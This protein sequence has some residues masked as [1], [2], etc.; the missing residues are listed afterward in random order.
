MTNW[1]ALFVYRL[2]PPIPHRRVSAGAAIASRRFA[3]G[4]DDAAIFEPLQGRML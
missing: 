4:L 1:L 3:F 2:L